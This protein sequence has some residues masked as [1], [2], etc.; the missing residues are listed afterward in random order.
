LKKDEIPDG[1]A[2]NS[3]NKNLCRI[4]RWFTI[5]TLPAREICDRAYRWVRKSTPDWEFCKNIG[6]IFRVIRKCALHKKW[7]KDASTAGLWCKLWRKNSKRVRFEA[8]WETPWLVFILVTSTFVFRWL[9]LVTRV[10][11]DPNFSN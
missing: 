1:D 8:M 4:R 2:Q 11:S 7:T 10:V 6:T 9:L 3:F 5:L